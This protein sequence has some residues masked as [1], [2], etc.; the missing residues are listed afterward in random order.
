M[1]FKNRTYLLILALFIIVF[2][3]EGLTLFILYSTALDQQ[4]GQLM[5]V[6]KSQSRLMESV[7]RF[8]TKFSQKD[9]VSGASGATLSQVR[10]AH[11]NLLGFG[12][13]GEFILAKLENEAIVFLLQP[14]FDAD[15]SRQYQ[16]LDKDGLY[17]N[18]MRLALSGKSGT[19]IAHDYR[20]EIVLAAYE[21]VA[22]LHYGIVAKI[23]LS[24]IREPY[25]H[26]GLISVVIAMLLISLGGFFFLRITNPMVKRLQDGEVYN[27][28]LFESSP[29]GLALCRMDGS[30][31]DANSAY[32]DIFGRSVDEIQK[33][34][35]WDITP[36]DYAEEEQRQ[37]ESL[38]TT[39][40]YGPYEKE[41]FHKDGRRI[42][43]S[44]LGQILERDG[45][46]YIWSSVEN[47]SER[48][49]V[50]QKAKDAQQQL[51]L[52][53]NSTGEAIY[54]VDLNGNCTF[55]NPACAYAIG[56]NN[57]DELLG[58]SMHEVM[59]HT[60][61][62]GSHY[63]VKEC[64][65]YQ[66]HVKGE[67]T[68]VDD[69]VFWRKDGTSFPVEYSS[70]PIRQEE[71]VIGS[72]VT[73]N[74]IS[75]RINAEAAL[76]EASELNERII[77]ESPIGLAIY[78]HTGQCIAAN[79]SV[80]E[81]TGATQEQ[82][83]SQNYNN[84]ESW[85][86]S[87][88]YEAANNCIRT[89]ERVRHAFHVV[90]TFGKQVF[91]DC[92]FVPFKLRGEQ[93]MLFMLDDITERKQA[94]VASAE[95]ETRLVEAQRLA[96]V[97]S[98]ELGI[99]NNELIWS[100]EIFH[101][102]ELDKTQF[103]ASY[104]AFLDAIHPE[105]RDR[106]NQAYA[107]SLVNQTAYEIEHRLQMSDGKIKYVRE[108]CESF[109][110]ADGKSVRSVGTVQD[111]T[112]IKIAELELIKY[113]EHL[114]ELVEERTQKLQDT[115]DELVRKERLATLGQLTATVSHE[116][117]NPL[118]AMKPSLY[119]VKKKSDKDD[120]RVQQAIERV[121][122]NIN[123]C[124][125]IIDELL[126]F[127]RIS[128]LDRQVTRIDNWLESVVDEQEVPKGIQI[129]KDLSLKDIELA[130]DNDRLLRAV[131]NVV[132]NAIHAMLDDNL[133]VRD[134]KNAR[135]C[136]KTQCNNKRIEIVISDTGT[137]IPEEIMEK[138][139]EPLF[140]TK[141]FG[142]G[143]GMPVVKQIMEQHGGGIEIDSEEGK[144]TSVTLW[145][146]GSKSEQ[147]ARGVVA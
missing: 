43:V 24:E 65:I 30:L 29:I 113:R 118:G 140:S 72:V 105:D 5:A 27:R 119:I 110:D 13:T 42:P 26:V 12:E 3:V 128:G 145:L 68:H 95:S 125:H 84:I 73:F 102:F 77:N 123:R 87:G 111:I 85:K 112:D 53:L 50:E 64:R 60:R 86:K 20:G 34:S 97:G 135:L 80:A 96:K 45:E 92:L 55:A 129:E 54:G 44:L 83:L 62:D 41:Y 108:T 7:A 141:G 46:K 61:S 138:I 33:L 18:P 144:G 109:F 116:L 124:D 100:D 93:R 131:I 99:Q 94:E 58:R 74:D 11:N 4:R 79:S 117:R 52:L 9:H 126:D 132:E 104:E 37:L 63:P 115:Q 114:E 127:T 31:V 48:K 15:S 56:Y 25:I 69:E 71:K 70:Y 14:R 21:P 2:I 88:L 39:G 32:A 121:D 90:T 98:W 28:T 67:H 49:R 16:R 22:I 78:D 10:E 89:Q 35:Y 1:N 19:V 130:I 120:E 91:L 136:I 6:V 146:P 59:H 133:Q 142:V 122:R 47:I 51:Q 40:Y 66:A 147:D 137:G 103:A 38:N 134:E 107:D 36:E 57:V 106:V 82:V 81:M 75:E 76:H 139:F 23:D 8:D 101:I 17:P 143:L